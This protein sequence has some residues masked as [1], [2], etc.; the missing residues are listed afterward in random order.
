MEQVFQGLIDR[1][2]AR[3]D[4]KRLKTIFGVNSQP[5]F[6]AEAFF[7]LKTHNSQ[8]KGCAAA[9]PFVRLALNFR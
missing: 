5:M 4:V 7:L 2:G 6:D 9:S 1:T 8:R 3:L